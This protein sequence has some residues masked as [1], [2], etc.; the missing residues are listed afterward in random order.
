[1]QRPNSDALR[2]LRVEMQRVGVHGEQR[3]PRVVGFADGAARAVFVNVA[4]HE[5]LEVA[6][7]DSR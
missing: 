7:K 1:M 6:T 3:E 5:V 2:V 4:D